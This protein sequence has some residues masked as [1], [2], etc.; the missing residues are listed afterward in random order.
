MMNDLESY[1]NP[2][3]EGTHGRSLAEHLTINRYFRIILFPL[4]PCQQITSREVDTCI[5]YQCLL[6]P[7]ARKC[8]TKCQVLEADVVGTVNIAG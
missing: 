7:S 1:L 4:G 8:E 2:K 5:L 6:Y 3:I